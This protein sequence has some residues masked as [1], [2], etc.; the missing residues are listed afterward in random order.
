MKKTIAIIAL[1]AAAAS[2]TF[3]QGLVFFNNQNSTKVSTN[4]VANG[5]ASGLTAAAGGSFYYALFYSTTV[6]T[7]GGSG[8]AFAGTNSTGSYAFNTAGWTSAGLIG[9]NS[10]ATTGRFASSS[11]DAGNN[12]IVSGLAGVTAANFVIIGWSANIGNTVTALQNYLANPNAQGFF[13]ESAVSGSI[14]TGNG[15]TQVTPQLFGVTAPGIGGFTL[16]V[17]DGAV[18]EPRTMV[19][20]GLG[21]LSLLAF[22][23]KK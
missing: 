10:G 13:G 5:A 9:T 14:T 12:S 3:A 11:S 18:P 15:G 19:L 6:T 22:R 21:G 4:S 1:V 7:V 8:A 16:G 2:T 20:A 17:V 23:R